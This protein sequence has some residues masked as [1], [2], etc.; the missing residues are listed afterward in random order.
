MRRRHGL[1][2]FAPR[3]LWKTRQD[4]RIWLHLTPGPALRSYKGPGNNPRTFELPRTSSQTQLHKLFLRFPSHRQEGKFTRNRRQT[5]SY[6]LETSMSKRSQPAPQV[7]HQSACPG[8]QN[9]VAHQTSGLLATHPSLWMVVTPSPPN[10]L[11]IRYLMH[12][13]VTRIKLPALTILIIAVIILL[14]SSSICISHQPS[15]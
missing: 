4:S 8:C 15:A 3:L 10:P 6:C 7:P 1:V 2:C 5:A 13:N 14:L 12:M 9:L 11:H